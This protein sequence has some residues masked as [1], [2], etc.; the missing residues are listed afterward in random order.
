MPWFILLERYIKKYHIVH[1][2]VDDYIPFVEIFIIPY[3]L[4]FLYVFFTLM[5]FLINTDKEYFV[6]SLYLYTGMT[7]FLIVSTIY[8]TGHLLRPNSFDRAN[9]F[10]SLVSLLY[11]MDTPTNI[12]PSI[13]VFNSCACFVAI[14]KNKNLRKKKFI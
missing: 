7:I 4:W 5:Y 14:F 9:I 2:P 11:Y 1:I 8:P 12:L 10:T 13:H 6:F 3:L